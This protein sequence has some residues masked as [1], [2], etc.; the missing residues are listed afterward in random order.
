MYE[1]YKNS[2]GV[3]TPSVSNPPP[4]SCKPLIAVRRLTPEEQARRAAIL[5]NAPAK[6]SPIPCNITPSTP[7]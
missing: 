1:S 6:G 2:S 5:A 7:V 4:N 3:F